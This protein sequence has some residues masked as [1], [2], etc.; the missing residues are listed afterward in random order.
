MHPDAVVNAFRTGL[1]RRVIGCYD[2]GFVT[3]STQMVEYPNH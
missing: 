3:G 2:E 1:T